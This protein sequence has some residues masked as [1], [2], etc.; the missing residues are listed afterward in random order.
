M[1]KSQELLAGFGLASVVALGATAC[2][3]HKNSVM[4]TPDMSGFLKQGTANT[5]F[6][7]GPR[8]CALLLRSAPKISGN[9]IN[10]PPDAT[11]V[12]W[13]LEAYNGQPG[14]ALN[15]ICYDPNGQSITP[16]EGTSTS[17]VWY[18]VVVPEEHV[19]N[20]QV[21]DDPTIK[22]IKFGGHTA[23]IGWASVE[24]FGQSTPDPRVPACST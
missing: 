5:C 4:L 12:P 17:P 13:P 11:H 2:S 1:R 10:T 6:N 3:A 18:E 21:K 7:G 22:A 19:L 20:P 9:Y 15:I 8:P 14:D 16:Y 23:V 24:W